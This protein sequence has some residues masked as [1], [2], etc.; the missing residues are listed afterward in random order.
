MTA[1]NFLLRAMGLRLCSAIDIKMSKRSRS[2]FR[3]QFNFLYRTSNLTVDKVIELNLAQFIDIIDFTH[4]F[5]R[6]GL[7]LTNYR[8]SKLFLQNISLHSA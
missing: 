4:F 6:L 7:H 2:L 5:I 3:H 8:H 1:L